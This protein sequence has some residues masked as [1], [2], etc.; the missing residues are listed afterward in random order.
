MRAKRE[1]AVTWW[2]PAAQTRPVLDSSSF[3]PVPT[4]PRKLAAILHLA[5]SL[6]EL[7]AALCSVCVQK[8][9]RRTEKSVNTHSRLRY[10]LSNNIFLLQVMYRCVSMIFIVKCV[11]M[12]SHCLCSA[13]KEKHDFYCSVTPW[14][15]TWYC[16]VLALYFSLLYHLLRNRLKCQNPLLS[17]VRERERETERESA[18]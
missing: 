17:Y 18:L 16:T 10:F 8:E 3:V 9:T 6:F 4:L 15:C 7:V 14:N 2:N 1:R 12:F 11:I 5:F 13:L